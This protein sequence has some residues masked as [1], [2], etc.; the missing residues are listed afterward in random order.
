VQ[1]HVVA[2][3]PEVRSASVGIEKARLLLR[4]AEVQ[5]IPN[6]T[7]GAGYVRQN[8]NQSDDWTIGVSA[9]IPVWNRNQGNI[10]AAQAMLG[11]AMEEVARV[12]NDLADRVAVAMREFAA[13]SQRATDLRELR[14]KAAQAVDIVRDAQTMTTLQRLESQRSLSIVELEYIRALGDAWKAAS[15]I[16]GLTLEEQWPS[17]N[18]PIEN[19]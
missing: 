4:R 18:V 19:K 11:E 7:I 17:A 16:S 5:R 6:V 3:H 10:Q 1:A 15:V 2:I 9:P 8:Q 13:A 12:E 14:R